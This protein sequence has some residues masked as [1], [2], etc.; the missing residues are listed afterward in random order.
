MRERPSV[1]V[2]GAGP[3]GAACALALARD[4]IETVVLDKARFPRSKACAGGLSP[5]ARRSLVELD[6]WDEVVLETQHVDTVRLEARSPVPVTVRGAAEGYVVPR[7]ILDSIVLGGARVAGAEVREGWRVEEVTPEGGVV[8][9]RARGPGGEAVLEAKWVVVAAGAAW[10]RRIDGRRGRI[11]HAI[12]ARYRG[13]DHDRHAIELQFDEDLHPLYGWVFPEPGGICNV[14]VGIEHARLG[15]RPLG[16]VFRSF[17]A[18]RLGRRMEGAEMIG[19]PSGHPI[20]ASPWP[21]VPG[22]PGVL[23]AGEAARLVNPLTGEGIAPALRSG[24]LA[25]RTIAAAHGRGGARERVLEEYA[26][27][28][29]RDVGPSLLVG[30]ALRTL[31]VRNL[32]WIIR[33]R[34]YLKGGR[35]I[36]HAIAYL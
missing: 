10:R 16:D 8:R 12:M 9:V 35:R 17:L 34:R 33:H 2:V 32:D 18:R 11:I 25:A 22:V 27:L 5:S 30:E 14:G 23:L 26:A 24:I 29:R 36:L 20:M 19:R 21:G 4:G 28:L 1:V 6:L 3:S 15:G 7:R 31:A 13:L